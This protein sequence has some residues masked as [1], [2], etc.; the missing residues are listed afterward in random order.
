MGKWD[1]INGRGWSIKMS[2]G[3]FSFLETTEI[4]LGCSKMDNFHLKK[5]YCTPG[6]NRENWLCPSEKY[7]SYASVL[8]GNLDHDCPNSNSLLLHLGGVKQLG[9]KHLSQGRNTPTLAGF[10]PTTLWSWSSF[11]FVRS[12]CF[13]FSDAFH[14]V[15]QP[16]YS[17]ITC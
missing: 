10:E 7:S 8:V 5:T 1:I 6:K 12:P 11:R 17:P 15:Q 2:K 9:I 4:G 14:R 3:L 13:P 16:R